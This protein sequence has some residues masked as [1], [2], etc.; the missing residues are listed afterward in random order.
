MSELI[1][2]LILDVIETFTRNSQHTHT[3]EINMYGVMRSIMHKAG[4]STAVMD[5]TTCVITSNSFEIHRPYGHMWWFSVYH[6][7]SS[8]CV[9][10]ADRPG[11]L[12]G[13]III[14]SAILLIHRRND[15]FGDFCFRVEKPHQYYDTIVGSMVGMAVAI[16]FITAVGCI[17]LMYV[18]V[19]V[20]IG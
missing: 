19:V 2:R 7:I 3:Y 15:G 10:C 12:G 4:I 1:N 8:V 13:T 16:S 6:H 5:N 18:D 20:V 14:F 17:H 11:Q 9:F